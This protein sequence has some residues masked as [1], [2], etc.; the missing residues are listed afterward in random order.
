MKYLLYLDFNIHYT[1]DYYGLFQKE[2]KIMKKRK[3]IIY[4]SLKRKQK[5]IIAVLYIFLYLICGAMT[6][7]VRALVH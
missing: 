1:H 4:F 2:Q 3:Q 5:L 7:I 6:T